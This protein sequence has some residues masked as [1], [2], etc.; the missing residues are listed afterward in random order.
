[1]LRTYKLG[2]ADRI[3]VVLTEH[4]GK[5]RAVAKGVRKTM[6]KFGARLEP[7]SHVRLLLYRGPRARHRQPGRVDRTAGAAAR[8]P[9]PGVAGDGRARGGRPARASSASRT[10]S[11]TAWWWACCAR[12]PT[13]RR[14]W[15][16]R[17]SSGRCSPPKASV[18]SSTPACAAARPRSASDADTAS[19]WWPS[20]STRAACCAGRAVPGVPISPA[21]LGLLRAILGGRLH[22]ALAAPESPA[23][24]EVGR[25][26]HQGDGA[27]PRTPPPLGRH[28]RALTFG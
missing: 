7:M 5:V 2:E 16:C 20:T 4:H 23:T 9:R 17:R 1:M 10:R 6:S 21:A 8:Q 15:W 26:G 12:S 25:P 13:G 11:S 24:H 18:P 27:P 19:S 14:R 22:E 28:L 3:V